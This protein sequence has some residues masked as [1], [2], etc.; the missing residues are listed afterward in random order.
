[1]TQTLEAET[2][3]F[4]LE[5]LYLLQILYNFIICC[6]QK[7]KSKNKVGRLAWKAF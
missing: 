4:G 1:M 7:S 3:N 5:N 2:N 6:K